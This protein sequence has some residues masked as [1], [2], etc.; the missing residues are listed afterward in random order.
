MEIVILIISILGCI[1]LYG[2][3]RVMRIKIF[4]SIWEQKELWFIAKPKPVFRKGDGASS[5]LYL[6]L[7][8]EG[9][10]INLPLPN[11]YNYLKKLFP[12]NGKWEGHL[13]TV[14]IRCCV[15][16]KDIIGIQYGDLPPRDPEF[17]TEL[18]SDL[19]PPNQNLK[20]QTNRA[21][22]FLYLSVVAVIPA[23][24]IFLQLIAGWFR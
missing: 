7:E 6:P 11:D 19:T 23:A 20:N 24:Y 4:K 14:P 8:L 9:N 3:Y 1:S 18:T 17:E 21:N 2:A 5:V 16:G 10:L 12:K 15:V 13:F 22:I